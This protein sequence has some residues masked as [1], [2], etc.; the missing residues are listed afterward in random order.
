MIRNVLRRLTVLSL[1]SFFVCCSAS[2]VLSSNFLSNLDASFSEFNPIGH[3]LVDPINEAVSRLHLSGFIRMDATF[4]V[5]GDD[6]CIGDGCIDKDWRAQKVEWLLELEASYRLNDN[7]E[8]N[9]IT[10]FLYDS[11]YDWQHS[12][13]LYADRVDT[14]S[15]YYH[16]GEQILRELYLKG[17]ASNFVLSLGK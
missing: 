15:H 4:N 14:T 1:G 16:K 6:H 17:F 3:H 9:A 2:S 13:G 5:H 10:H 11:A 8:V 12:R 7:W